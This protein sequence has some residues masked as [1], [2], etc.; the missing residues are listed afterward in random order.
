VEAAL[1]G[2]LSPDSA[3]IFVEAGFA[4]SLPEILDT[5]IGCLGTE[6]VVGATAHGVL[7]AGQEI[8]NTP[9]VAI[10]AQSGLEAHPFLIGDLASAEAGAGA[11]IAAGI[12]E[13]PRSEDLIVLLPDLGAVQ[14]E[15][16]LEGIRQ[17]LAPAVVVGAAAADPISQAPLQWC[18]RRLERGG[19]AGMVLRGARAPR[20]GVTQACRPTTE[21]MR[22]TRTQGHW[23]LGLDGRPALDVYREVA[24]GPLA[25]DLRNA[26]RFL[27][28]AI[29]CGEPEQL[30]PG[31]YIVRHVVGFAEKEKAFAIP[32]GVKPGD[33]IALA[34]R[35]REAARED[36]KAMLEGFD[37]RPASLGLYFNCCARGAGFF[38]VEG[39]EAAYLERSLG[40]TPVAGMFGSCEIGPI[41][42]RTELLTYTG[43][44]ALLDA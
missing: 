34:T 6:A 26:A 3:L 23:I 15:R 38:G 22:V 28:V 18:G 33:L 7:G 5:A 20:V 17:S 1:E 29:P 2:G 40:S 19:A 11:E 16:F 32:D 25:E 36:L 31:N 10:V 42:D 13:P 37:G 39:L 21:L 14:P 24:R 12:G 30:C 4:D 8:E 43:V 41:G 35:D 27:L 9:S 44:L